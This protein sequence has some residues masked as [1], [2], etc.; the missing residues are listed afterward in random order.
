MANAGEISSRLR[1][2]RERRGE[3]PAS[4]GADERSSVHY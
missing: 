1:L 4:Q 3:E 2:H